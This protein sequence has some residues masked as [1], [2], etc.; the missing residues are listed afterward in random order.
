LDFFSLWVF[1]DKLGIVGL[2]ERALQELESCCNSHGE[3][4]SK[5][6]LRF[7]Y[8]NT[9]ESSD[10]RSTVLRVLLRRYFVNYTASESMEAGLMET[11]ATSHTMLAFDLLK[12]VHGHTTIVGSACNIW[13]CRVHE[14]NKWAEDEEDEQSDQD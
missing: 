6:G 7:A 4:F 11:I 14:Q 8:G 5:E 1:A 2:A 9:S 10:L 3:I 13:G 12:K